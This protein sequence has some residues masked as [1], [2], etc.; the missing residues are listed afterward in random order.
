MMKFKYK[1]QIQI[2][3]T[4]V[5]FDMIKPYLCGVFDKIF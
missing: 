3:K 1:R 4:Y 2:Q 5:E